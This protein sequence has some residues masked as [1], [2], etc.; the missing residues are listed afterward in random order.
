MYRVII[1]V[2]GDRAKAEKLVEELHRDGYEAVIVV[3]R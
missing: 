2:A 1:P 3:R